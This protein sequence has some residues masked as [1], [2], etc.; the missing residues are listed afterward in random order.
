L[1]DRPH[2]FCHKASGEGKDMDRSKETK[3]SG[4]ICLVFIF[5][6]KYDQN[7]KKLESIYGRRFENIFHLVP[8]YDG[9]EPNVI[10]V[11]D[12]SFKFQGYIAQAY[13]RIF[14]PKYS[15]YVFVGD[16]LLLN[17]RINADN[18]TRELNLRDNSGYIKSLTV[19]SD[20]SFEWPHLLPV[21]EAFGNIRGVEYEREI[22]DKAEAFE[23]LRRHGYTARPFG[24]RNMRGGNGYR[25]DR[26]QI[27][28]AGRFL[29]KNY[30]DRSLRYPLLVAYS[31]FTVIPANALQQFC[32]LCG[33]FSAMNMFVEVAIPTAMVLSCDHIVEEKD[34]TWRGLEVWGNEYNELMKRQRAS[35]FKDV[36]DSFGEHQLYLHPVKLSQWKDLSL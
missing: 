14:D 24:F 34:T 28:A 21:L 20:Q 33:V 3:A 26:K 17:P 12:N 36:L 4:E 9:N 18:L 32:Q 6:H 22:P 10:P 19:L 27:I 16:D 2:A 29:L 30:R 35:E 1:G 31:D 25:Y 23:R 5:N 13:A 11:Y 15:H 7:I 8:F